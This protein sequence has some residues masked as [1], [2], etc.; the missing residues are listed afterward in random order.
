MSLTFTPGFQAV[1]HSP[2]LAVG[3]IFHPN[4]PAK[5]LESRRRWMG[6]TVDVFY[7]MVKKLRPGWV[8]LAAHGV[9]RPC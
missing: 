1:N 5:R 4:E 6:V 8:G 2:A 3:R 7:L 9:R